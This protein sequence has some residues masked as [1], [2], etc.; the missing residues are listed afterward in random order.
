MRFNVCA[1]CSMGTCPYPKRPPKMKR[2]SAL[3][4]DRWGGLRPA[5]RKRRRRGPSSAV[6]HLSMRNVFRTA[7][8]RRCFHRGRR[9]P[10]MTPIIGLEAAQEGQLL[11]RRATYFPHE[12]Q[13]NYSMHAF[14]ITARTHGQNC[15]DCRLLISMYN[16]GNEIEPRFGPC[17]QRDGMGN[18]HQWRFWVAG[19]LASLP[20][21]LIADALMGLAY[22]RET[23]R[24]M[25]ATHS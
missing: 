7:I 17:N 18:A 8:K 6:R 10:D 12:I 22:P 19:V 11:L 15:I 20:A 2:R 14:G 13:T 3:A 23:V 1:S 21:L 25:I 16:P 5:E 4:M 24:A 9:R